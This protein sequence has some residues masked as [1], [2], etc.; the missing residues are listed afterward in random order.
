MDGGT[1]KCWAYV[2]QTQ[3]TQENANLK[4]MVQA[5]M[6]GIRA[7]LLPKR[8]QR[9][10]LAT[11]ARAPSLARFFAPA[12]GSVQIRKTLRVLHAAKAKSV[13]ERQVIRAELS[14]EASLRR[15]QEESLRER[16]ERQ[17]AA[18]VDRVN[19]RKER[20]FSREQATCCSI[21]R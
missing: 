3:K 13:V 18:R 20:G 16:A 6:N 17:E 15:P 8:L 2:N 4:H 10:R 14:R 5:T 9:A 1:K 21:T 12:D 7:E 11:I 19:M